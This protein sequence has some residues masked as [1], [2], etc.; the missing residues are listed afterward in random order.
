M[1]VYETTL[2]GVVEVETPVYRDERGFFLE[3]YRQ[4]WLAPLGIDGTFVQDNHSRSHRGVVR[5]LHYQLER[6]QGKLVRVV[7][8]AIFDVVVDVRRGSPHFGN[9]CGV[10]LDDVELRML[11]VP[12]GFAH[13]FITLSEVADISYKCTDYYH[14]ASEVGIAWNDPTI[15]IDWPIDEVVLSERDGL[16]PRLD[17][18]APDRLPR[19]SGD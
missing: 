10:H 15:A 1:K 3:S 9:W 19:Y 2:P 11:Y 14:P 4:E 13:G 7:R 12:P 6:P 8:G 17:A 18:I 5:G 16:N